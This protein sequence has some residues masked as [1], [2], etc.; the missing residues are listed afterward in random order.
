MRDDEPLRDKNASTGSAET[1]V[2]TPGRSGSLGHGGKVADVRDHIECSPLAI[3]LLEGATRA[4]RYANPAFSGLSGI[5]ADVLL[6]PVAADAVPRA[7]TQRVEELLRAAQ[8]TGAAQGELE[9]ELTGKDGHRLVWGVVIWPAV[10]YR[11]RSTNL[12]VQVRD[13]TEEAR[14]RRRQGELAEQLREINQKLVLASLREADLKDTAI[15]ANNAKSIFLA[16]MS[17]E[18]RTP[19]AA[20]IGYQELLASAITGPITDAQAAQL[21]RIKQSAS[22]LLALIDQVLTLARVEA[23]SESVDRRPIAARDVMEAAGTMVAPLAAGKG[24]VLIVEAPHRALMLNTDALKVHQILV[25]L[26]ANAV[27]FS[28]R[29]QIRLGLKES[30][31]NALFD[32]SDTG[33]G[34]PGEYL[35]RVFS[36]FWQVRQ[37]ANRKIGGTGLGLSVARDLARLLGGDV[38]VESVLG[39]GSTFTLRVP[40]NAPDPA[41]AAKAS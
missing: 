5:G 16:T 14:A 33:I 39:S 26:L 35:E 21:A 19:L 31:N 36:P 20:I 6:G 12:V 38:T 17:H 18:L 4:V 28:E 11:G 7:G 23:R 34:I 40:V 2:R 15:A 9:I 24:L 25:N 41:A 37:T 10:G 30:A 22:H 29:G 1:T 8:D 3:A 27:K 13:V 32:V